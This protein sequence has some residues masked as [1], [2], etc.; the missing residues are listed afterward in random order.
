MR[1]DIEKRRRLA[2]RG[3][4]EGGRTKGSAGEILFLLGA[5][6]SLLLLV[7]FAISAPHPEGQLRRPLR[8]TPRD[9]ARLF[10]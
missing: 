6:P 4:V 8:N 10:I 1:S 9:R 7:L 3:R 2:A 5:D